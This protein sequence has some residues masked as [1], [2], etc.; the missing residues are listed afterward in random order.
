MGLFPDSAPRDAGSPGC[1][2]RT[3]VVFPRRLAALTAKEVAK[4]PQEA[5]K[6]CER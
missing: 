1:S 5:A 6:G 4:T 3:H 2:C